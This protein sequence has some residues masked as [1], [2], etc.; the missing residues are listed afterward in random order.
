M[1]ALLLIA[2]AAALGSAAPVEVIHLGDGREI[3]APVVKET[4]ENL[5]VDLGFTI[6]PIPKKEVVRRVPVA[7]EEAPTEAEASVEEGRLW[8]SLKRSEVSVKENV[9]RVSD[10]VVLIQTPSGSG[11]GFIIDPS[12]YVITNDHVIQGDTKITVTL[13]EEENGGLHK[14]KVEDVRIV[15]TNAYVDLA[16][17]KLCG[18]DMKDLPWVP[19]GNGED[20][21]V[22][23]TAFAI[24]NPLGM[25]R[26]VSEGIISTLNR[27]FDGLTYLQITTQINPGNSGG[28]LFNL[29]GEV[30]GVT[31]MG[32]LFSDGM[33]FAIPV[34]RVKWF[35]AN[36]QAFAYDKDNPNTGY[37]Y[38]VP[39]GKGKPAGEETPPESKEAD[40]EEQVEEQSEE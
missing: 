2:I 30:I 31:N 15:G 36:R 20:Q 25:E 33:N 12:G 16:L 11:S 19:L 32:I 9:T 18:E 27:P 14:N 4:A 8:R 3:K 29:N 17:L 23:E 7:G 26:T 6:M 34:E 10:A 13:F 21:R 39:P 1:K 38:L 24:G 35:L 5:F 28:P 40:Q 37:R 22:G